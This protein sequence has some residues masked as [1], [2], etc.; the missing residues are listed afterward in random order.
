MTKYI[1]MEYPDGVFIFTLRTI[2]DTEIISSRHFDT[3][4]DCER[5]VAL[6]REISSN[7]DNYADATTVD[8]WYSF[9][10]TDAAGH[11]SAK[12]KPY[13]TKW[14]LDRAKILYTHVAIPIQFNVNSVESSGGKN[15]KNSQ[16][17]KIHS[18]RSTSSEL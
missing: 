11:Y 2:S 3:L 9:S 12:S 14:R 17:T 5:A 13:K 16:S 1:I 6:V 4:H 18:F 8:N 7:L 15:T 10:L